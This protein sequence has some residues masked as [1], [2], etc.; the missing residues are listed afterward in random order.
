MA[1][2][3]IC[4]VSMVSNNTVATIKNKQFQFIGTCNINIDVFLDVDGSV[5]EL[6]N[7]VGVP[8]FYYVNK[9]GIVREVAHQLLKNYRESL[10]N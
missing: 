2:L 4:P 1:Y 6:Y 8:T 7:I 3:S 10:T 5:A 9:D